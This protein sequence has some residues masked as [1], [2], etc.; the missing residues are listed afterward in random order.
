MSAQ[1]DL[2]AEGPPPPAELVVDLRDR[3]AWRSIPD[4]RDES[5]YLPCVVES[6]CGGY[7]ITWTGEAGAAQ[8]YLAFKRNFEINRR[9]GE[10]QRTNPLV[11][12]G[13]LTPEAARQACAQHAEGQS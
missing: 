2:F 6:V 4:P 12:G 13:Y 5:R 10:L 9:T 8:R 11:I 7:T 1:P 3:S